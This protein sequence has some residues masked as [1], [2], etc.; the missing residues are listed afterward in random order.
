MKKRI[1][2][3]AAICVLLLVVIF[4]GSRSYIGKKSADEMYNRVCN[5]LSDY[6]NLPTPFVSGVCCFEKDGSKYL[7]V[8]SNGVNITGRQLA[9]G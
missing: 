7:L 2:L 3:L 8:K 6:P 9:G 1:L 5:V 4:I